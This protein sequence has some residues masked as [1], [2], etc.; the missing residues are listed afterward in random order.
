MNPSAPTSVAN[1]SPDSSAAL[2]RIA[3][4][5]PELTKGNVN[6]WIICVRNSLHAYNLLGYVDGSI[7]APPEPSRYTAT[8]EADPAVRFNVYQQRYQALIA[9]NPSSNDASLAIISLGKYL[10]DGI[11]ETPIAQ[12]A[13]DAAVLAVQTYHQRRALAFSLV[14]SSLKGE[15]LKYVTRV[16]MYDTGGLITLIKEDL[17]ANNAAQISTLCE[18]FERIRMGP[19]ESLDSYKHRFD[20]ARTDLDLLK[21]NYTNAEAYSI[22]RKGLN[23]EKYR[24]VIIQMATNPAIT[25]HDAAYQYIKTTEEILYSAFLNQGYEPSKAKQAMHASISPQANLSQG[26]G[27]N[28]PSNR[29]NKYCIYHQTHGHDSSECKNLLALV[30]KLPPPKRDDRGNNNTN[31]NNNNTSENKSNHHN[32]TNNNN[33]NNNNNKATNN[34]NNNKS[35]GNNYNNN[36]NR[37]NNRRSSN[38]NNNNNN[39]SANNTIIDS[40]DDN[41]ANNNSSSNN[42]NQAQA[43]SATAS[44]YLIC[45]EH[46]EFNTT[47]TNNKIINHIPFSDPETCSIA[48]HH[49]A[50]PVQEEAILDCG[51]THHFIKNP[52]MFDYI[53]TDQIETIRV[54]D[55]RVV[56]SKG[57]GPAA[58]LPDATFTPQFPKSLFSAN[59]L[60]RD[61]NAKIHIYKD[62]AELISEESDTLMLR[63]NLKDNLYTAD[64]ST[65]WLSNDNHL[66]SHTDTDEDV[67]NASAHLTTAIVSANIAN[68]LPTDLLTLLHNRFCHQSAKILS[69]SIT[70]NVLPAQLIAKY[71]TTISALQKNLRKHYCHGCCIGK[72]TRVSHP[73][74]KPDDK[75]PVTKGSIIYNDIKGPLPRT[76]FHD[77]YI[78]LYIDAATD[79]AWVFISK[80]KSD[81][82]HNFIDLVNN[83]ISPLSIRSILHSDPAGENISTDLRNYCST[84]NITLEYTSTDSPQQNGK[85]ERLNRTMLEAILTMLTTAELSKAYWPYA[86]RTFIYTRNRTRIVRDNKTAFELWFNYK[87][88]ISN[89]RTFGCLSFVHRVH[90]S[91]QTPLSTKSFPGIF[92]GYDTESQSY[93]VL[94]PTSN[95]VHK[96]IHVTF[97]ETQTWR[98]FRR[99]NKFASILP[100]ILLDSDL[101]PANDPLFAGEQQDPTPEIALDIPSILT[102]NNSSATSPS[103]SIHPNQNNIRIEID[104]STGIDYSKDIIDSFAPNNNSNNIVSSYNPIVNNTHDIQHNHYELSK[105]LYDIQQQECDNN[106]DHH[107]S[108][109]NF[110]S[111]NDL[112][113][114]DNLIANTNIN[115]NNNIIASPQPITNNTTNNISSYGRQRKHNTKYNDSYLLLTTKLRN[116]RE[117]LEIFSL[118]NQCYASIANVLPVVFSANKKSSSSSPNEI[119]TPKTYEEAMNCK[120]KLA[121]QRSMQR[122]NNALVDMGTWIYVPKDEAKGKH[123]F[124]TVW[125]YKVKALL[126]E[127]IYKSR[128]CFRGFSQTQGKDFDKTFSPVVRHTT[129]LNLLWLATYLD[130]EIHQLDFVTAYLNGLI[131]KDLYIHPPKGLENV[132][133]NHIL[134]LVKSLYGLKQ[135]GHIWNNTL[136]THLVNNL[137]YRR[138]VSDESI[139]IQQHNNITIVIAVYVDDLL[140]FGND[141]PSIQQLKLDLASKFK[142]KDL[143]EPTKFLGLTINRNRKA[144]TMNINQASYI[145]NLLD[146][147]ELNNLQPS[148]I[149]ADPK[150]KLSKAMA[151]SSKDDIAYMKGIPYR[152]TVGA[153]L[154]AALHTRPDITYAVNAVSQYVSNPGKE[155]WEAVKLIFSYLKQFKNLGITYRRKPPNEKSIIRPIVYS[156]ASHASRI[157]DRKSITGYICFLNH[158][159]PVSWK[160]R[161]QPIVATSSTES[162]YLALTEAVKEAIWLEMFFNELNILPVSKPIIFEDNKSTILIAENPVLHQ[163]TKHIDIRYHFIRQ[164]VK[165]KTLTLQ[166]CPTNKMIADMLTKA[167]Y[168]PQFT[169]L[170]ATCISSPG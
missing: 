16:P 117:D 82:Y 142:T 155:H 75:R 154:Y 127:L 42:N 125:V 148:F 53:S 120:D 70:N 152:E 69:T 134:K 105:Q 153:L 7:T 132:P 1:S 17:L 59:K 79:M 135:A 36:N 106:N 39:H 163:K 165:D 114:D 81:K 60:C 52:D 121:W 159:S 55:G 149:P 10:E 48:T 37:N 85:A 115:T 78:D 94:D 9:Q 161:V 19:K 76:M 13:Y 113:E 166:Y 38:Y 147:Y 2:S 96:S 23:V 130:W 86:V 116:T 29:S 100:D 101:P 170:N 45:T 28:S 67:I 136:S 64:V 98:S 20:Q 131:D 46:T 80:H 162:E 107:Y 102:P 110:D 150:A 160:T 111:N 124:D 43:N 24:S 129:I 14:Q 99:N 89:L 26:T 74:I 18:Q 164:H 144:G 139:F 31:R 35:R 95:K 51:A 5:I 54:A 104:N 122:E 11:T 158:H 57:H 168:K 119:F 108:S 41:T 109:I 30:A 3:S 47:L 12:A 44:A 56:H 112:V 63:F 145:Q 21:H 138:L 25:T 157:D 169:Y 27:G 151:P 141:L 143:G 91:Q 62:H 33:G 58:G 68:K 133:P 123:I 6:A 87:P 146:K 88:N 167:L 93:L 15:F 34:N 22:F 90:E 118:A 140:I 128:L 84:N 66:D 77:R 40:S 156:D 103:L 49:K 137:N 97:D 61:L 92:L 8:Y 71:G 72:S 32:K 83:F 65:N 50:T 73:S 126:N 4:S